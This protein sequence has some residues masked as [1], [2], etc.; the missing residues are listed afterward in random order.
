MEGDFLERCRGFARFLVSEEGKPPVHLEWD[1][2][3]CVCFE[4]RK[5]R[6]VLL[7]PGLGWVEHKGGKKNPGKI[8]NQHAES[9]C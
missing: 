3:D 2:R 8:E 4:L 6:F 7:S 5:A 9:G 1:S